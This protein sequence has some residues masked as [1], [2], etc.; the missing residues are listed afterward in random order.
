MTSSM[1]LKQHVHSWMSKAYSGFSNERLILTNFTLKDNC[2]DVY[3]SLFCRKAELVLELYI[4]SLSSYSQDEKSKLET[5]HERTRGEQG[6]RE[7]FF[8]LPGTHF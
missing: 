4:K 7:E 2:F 3:F 8:F 5:Q 6:Q 1:Y